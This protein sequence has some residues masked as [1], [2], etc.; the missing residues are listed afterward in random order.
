M[1]VKHAAKPRT[2]CPLYCTVD[3]KRGSA[4]HA[5]RIAQV[6]AST[7]NAAVTVNVIRRDAADEVE[8]VTGKGW[9][10]PAVAHLT[11]DEARTLRDALNVAV[12]LLDRT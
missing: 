3:H 6:D 10:E 4:E 7:E 8:L 12:V 9:N 5:H 2:R 11:A 1:A